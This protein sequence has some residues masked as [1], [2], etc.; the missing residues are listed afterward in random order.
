MVDAIASLA[1]VAYDN[2][3]VRPQINEDGVIRLT[4]SRHPVVEKSIRGFVPNDCALDGEDNRFLIITGPNMSGK[5]TYMR[6]VAIIVLMAHIGSFIPPRKEASALLT[7]SLPG[8]ALPM[9]WLGE[10]HLHGGDVETANILNNATRD[11]LII[12]DEIGRGT[13][14]FDGLS[15]AWAVAEH[16]TKMGS[17]AMFA[18]HYHELSEMEGLIPGVKNYC[19]AARELGED[20]VFLHRIIRGGTVKALVFKWPVGGNSHPGDRAAPR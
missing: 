19:I 7:A 16:I 3:Y 10:I 14:T 1:Q 15:I 13:H 17:K 6:Q 9:I 12:L 11:S 20:I 18:T 8:W 5:S 2:N 4:E